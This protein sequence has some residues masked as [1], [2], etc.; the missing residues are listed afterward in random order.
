MKAT[1]L[2]Q[3]RSTKGNLVFRYELNGTE[4]EIAQYQ[5]IQ[6]E[7]FK[8]DDITS[9]VLYFTTTFAGPAAKLLFNQANTKVFIDNSE[10]D[11]LTSLAAQYEGTAMGNAIAKQAADKMME[12][13]NAI[14]KIN[15][16]NSAD[17]SSSVAEVSQETAILGN[18]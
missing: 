1:Y 15:A 8:R 13:I 11:A 5:A 16:K 14:A 10:M 3:Y 12:W 4:A 17:V 7:N 2:S 18:I 6:G 9:K